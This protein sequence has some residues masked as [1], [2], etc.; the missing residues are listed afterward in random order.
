MTGR[1]WVIRVDIVMSALSSAIHKSGHYHVRPRPRLLAVF[2]C[3]SANNGHSR[4]SSCVLASLDLA[5]REARA[6][7]KRFGISTATNLRRICCRG[8]GLVFCSNRRLA[9]DFA[10]TARPRPPTADG[11]IG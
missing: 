10:G 6:V 11:H 9:K 4:C 8:V 1:L 2:L 3:R 7:T 5:T